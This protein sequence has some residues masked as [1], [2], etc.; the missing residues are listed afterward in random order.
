MARHVERR[1]DMGMKLKLIAEE[2]NEDA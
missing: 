1:R 2:G